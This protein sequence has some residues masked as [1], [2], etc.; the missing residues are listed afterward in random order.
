MRISELIH[1]L[2]NIRRVEGDLEIDLGDGRPMTKIE[3]TGVR[4]ESLSWPPLPRGERDEEEKKPRKR[5][6]RPLTAARR[7]E[8][9]YESPAEMTSR[10]LQKSIELSRRPS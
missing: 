4:A 3:V 2:E 1:K 8:T 5:S 7:R 6:A 9:T 10:A